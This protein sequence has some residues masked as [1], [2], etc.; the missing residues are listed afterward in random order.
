MDTLR[1]RW[2]DAMEIWDGS[3][4]PSPRSR[5]LLIKATICILLGR[6]ARDWMKCY[7]THIPI[8]FSGISVSWGG[9]DGPSQNWAEVAVPPGLRNWTYTRYTNGT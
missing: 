5:W 1:A 7:D 8:W 2:L 6:E 4:S 3:T 9:Y